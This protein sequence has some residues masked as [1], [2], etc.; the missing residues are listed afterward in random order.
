MNTSVFRTYAET[1]ASLD[2]WRTYVDP[3]MAFSDEEFAD[4]SILGRIEYITETFGPEP[5]NE[6]I[7]E[8]IGFDD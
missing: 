1:A 8:D 3:E 5:T 6:Q 7:N 4:M 2:L